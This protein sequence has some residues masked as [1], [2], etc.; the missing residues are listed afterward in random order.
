MTDRIGAIAGLAPLERY[1]RELQRPDFAADPAQRG[2]M[3]R[4]DRLYRELVRADGTRK[5]SWWARMRGAAMPAA[6]P[7]GIYLWGGV[8]R[9]KTLLVDMF[10][11]SLPFAARRRTHFH[12]FM[13]GVHH[14]LRQ[15]R[16]ERDPLVRV[17]R[18]FAGEFRVLVLDEFHVSDITDAMLLANLLRALFDHG[19]TLVTTSNDE[20][21]RLYWGGLQRERFLPAIA[22]LKEH[23]EAINLDSGVDYRLRV[24]ERAEIYLQ[25]LDAAAQAGLAAAFDALAPEPG[26]AGA[27]IEI[28]GRPLRT[29]RCADGVVWFDFAELCGGPR[30]TRDYIEIARCYQTLVLSNVPVFDEHGNDAARRFVHLIDELYD[31]NVKLVISA[32]APPAG[33][34]RGERLQGPF[35]RTASRLIEMQS[36]AYLASQHISD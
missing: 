36:H 25:P 15:L 8:G 6:G 30:G 24:L 17:G 29:V 16:D 23:T 14:E 10:Y 1:A 18:R 13:Q 22:L 33:L 28:D 12:R 7:R 34:Y 9:G 31:R 21:D 35:G 2:A 3:E 32:A 26:E 27:M 4:L 20:P 5:P 19:V 11:D